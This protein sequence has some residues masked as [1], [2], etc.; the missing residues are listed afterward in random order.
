MR[1]SPLR[2]TIPLF[3]GLQ[4]GMLWLQGVQIHHQNQ[5]L[6]GLREDIQVLTETLESH[7]GE[8]AFEEEPAAVPA[9]F[10]PRPQA[11]KKM[12]VLGVQEEQEAAAKELQAAR[13]SA[14]KSVKEARETQ[15]KLS[16]EE[17]ARKA[18]ETRKVQAATRTWQGWALGAA[19]LMALA[20]VGRA[21]LRRRG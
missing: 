1:R 6:A 20:L 8:A 14:Q 11:Q 15:V 2:W 4:L 17:N 9:G 5:V 19:G 13:E 10:L 21:F 16:L 12:A 18:E 3:L 7:Q